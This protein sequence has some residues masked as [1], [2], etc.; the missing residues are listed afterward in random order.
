M[1]ANGSVVLDEA[2]SDLKRAW[3]ETSFRMRERR[4][5]RILN[6]SSVSGMMAMP[7]M[8]LYSASKFALEGATES[9]W[10]EVR[11]FGIK[12]TRIASGLPVGGDLEYADEVTL[13]RALQGRR[14]L[15]SRA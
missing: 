8:A 15:E 9:L 6:V 11:P 3:S 7:T 5:G 12:V 10:Y 4:D 14:A 1:V 2:L 13:I